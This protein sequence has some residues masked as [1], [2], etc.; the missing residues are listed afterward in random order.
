MFHCV[1]KCLQSC[2]CVTANAFGID[3]FPPC[4]WSV[5]FLSPGSQ[6]PWYY[7]HSHIIQ[8]CDILS[9]ILGYWLHIHSAYTV[10]LTFFLPIVIAASEVESFPRPLLRLQ[11]EL[12]PS[13]SLLRNHNV[14]KLNHNGSPPKTMGTCGTDIDRDVEVHAGCKQEAKLEYAG[15]FRSLVHTSSSSGF[16]YL[17]LSHEVPVPLA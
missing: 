4:Y 5:V 12:P 3:A 7:L 9:C 6:L 2:F 10:V 13:P 17:V 1:Q 11:L 8:L 16:H 14:T 15:K